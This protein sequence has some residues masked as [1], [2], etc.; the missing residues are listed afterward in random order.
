MA[1]ST[2]ITIDFLLRLFN[3]DEIHKM[4]NSILDLKSDF[5]EISKLLNIP[6]NQNPKI[7]A[8]Y[9]KV[10]IIRRC[11]ISCLREIENDEKAILISIGVSF[12][13]FGI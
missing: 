5:Q 13:K 7:Q 6:Y 2:T 3:P 4:S 1:K 11:D 10:E 8:K 9:I 12:S